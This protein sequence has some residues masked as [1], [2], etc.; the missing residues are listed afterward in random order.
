MSGTS[1]GTVTSTALIAYELAK[2][3][4]SS[5]RAGSAGAP[6]RRR[7]SRLITRNPMVA[8]MNAAGSTHD[9]TIAAPVATG[10]SATTAIS[11]AADCPMFLI[12]IVRARLSPMRT[13]SCS[14]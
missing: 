11:L 10:M 4:K 8:V 1:S 12:A 9:Q 7:D 3:W 14:A 5:R 13:W 6:V 2:K